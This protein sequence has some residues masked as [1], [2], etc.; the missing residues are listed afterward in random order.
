MI[1]G[2]VAIISLVLDAAKLY[3]GPKTKRRKIAKQLVQLYQVLGQVMECGDQIVEGLKLVMKFHR[4]ILANNEYYSRQWYQYRDSYKGS[5]TEAIEYADRK[6]RAENP[7]LLVVTKEDSEFIRHIVQF[8]PIWCRG[9]SLSTYEH[10]IPKSTDDT[11]INMFHA[12][13][14]AGSLVGCLVVTAEKQSENLKKL[15]EVLQ[16]ERVKTIL[17]LHVDAEKGYENLFNLIID[18]SFRVHRIIN[19]EKAQQI[20]QAIVTLNEIRSLRK[21]LRE[22]L[23][24]KFEL[25][26]LL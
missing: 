12:V 14:L 5:I 6:R 3:D 11:E 9:I 15:I 25:E 19:R 13:S 4:Y 8:P 26:E 17:D 21:A 1:E 22:L 18:K 2:L 24:T 23:I 16:N 10:K 20:D 7:E